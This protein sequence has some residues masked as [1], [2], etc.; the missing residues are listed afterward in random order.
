[1]AAVFVGNSRLARLHVADLHIVRLRADPLDA[2]HFSDDGARRR[3][4]GVSA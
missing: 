1:M 2:H 4:A 3:P